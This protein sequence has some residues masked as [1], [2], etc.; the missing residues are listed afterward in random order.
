MLVNVLK[1]HAII[2]FWREK[3][4]GMDVCLPG[5]FVCRLRGW[6]SRDNY[7]PLILGH[8]LPKFVSS[9]A[10]KSRYGPDLIPVC[11]SCTPGGFPSECKVGSEF[12]PI[13]YNK[14][15]FCFLT[16][17]G[18]KRAINNRAHPR[19]LLLPAECLRRKFLRALWVFSLKCLGELGN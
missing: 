5:T 14:K 16:M 19:I 18:G 11:R 2:L 13:V 8:T 7:Y 9:S 10:F 15:S 12:N 6:Y 4:R 1:R 3:R 17:L